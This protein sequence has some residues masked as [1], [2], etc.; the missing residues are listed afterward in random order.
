MSDRLFPAFNEG[1]VRVQVAALRGRQSI[2][3]IEFPD[4]SS[5]GVATPA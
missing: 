5:Q 3:D 1:K 4:L 2:L